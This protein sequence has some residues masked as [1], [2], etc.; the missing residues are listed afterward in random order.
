MSIVH[1]VLHNRLWPEVKYAPAYV[2]AYV[3]ALLPRHVTLLR[4]FGHEPPPPPAVVELR[5][6]PAANRLRR[7]R[8]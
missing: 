4:C 3:P 7:R 2:P 5:A 1:Q 8:D 6:L